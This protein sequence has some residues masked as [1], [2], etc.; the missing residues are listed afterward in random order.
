MSIITE[1]RD[2]V[3]G[4]IQKHDSDLRFDGLVLDDEKIG[5]NASDRTYKLV[6]GD[7]TPTR[8]DSSYTADIDTQVWIYKAAD[9]NNRVNDFDNAYCKALDIASEIIDQENISQDM[10]IKSI[11]NSTITPEAVDDVDNVYRFR[12]QFITT[13][14]YSLNTN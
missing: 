2:Y 7:A 14:Y 10:F 5:L 6:I 12:I 8:L 1:I 9:L 3:S 13:V 11:S 4:Q